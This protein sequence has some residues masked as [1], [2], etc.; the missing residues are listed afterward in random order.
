MRDASW[1]HM[2][3]CK[4]LDGCGTLEWH[5]PPGSGDPESDPQAPSPFGGPGGTSGEVPPASLSDVELDE[6]AEIEYTRRIELFKAGLAA[7]RRPRER[8]RFR[9][10]TQRNC[11]EAYHSDA[12]PPHVAAV[13][14]R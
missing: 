5:E 9:D 12:S 13:L 4:G 1:C 8:R 6:L 10:Y 2:D 7:T 11:E 14:R 3:E